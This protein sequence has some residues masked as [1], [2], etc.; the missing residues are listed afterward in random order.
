MKRRAD[1]AIGHATPV[2][3]AWRVLAG[4]LGGSDRRFATFCLRVRG[5]EGLRSAAEKLRARAWNDELRLRPPAGPV[6]YTTVLDVLHWP[7]EQP[8]PALRPRALWAIEEE[9]RVAA[10]A[11]LSSLDDV[12]ARAARRRVVHP[13]DARVLYALATAA[14]G[15]TI[16]RP[17]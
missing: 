12:V 17:G 13:R 7:T 2:E 16:S 3:I 5:R 11:F 1:L 6:V 15:G 10:A 4:G 8:A 14:C 9:R